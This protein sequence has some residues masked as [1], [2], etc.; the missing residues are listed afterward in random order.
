MCI[1][2]FNKVFGEK[3]G[4]KKITLPASNFQV[5]FALNIK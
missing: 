2:N 5:V 4:N 1:L 3:Q